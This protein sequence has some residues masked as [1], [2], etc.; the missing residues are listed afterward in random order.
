MSSMSFLKSHALPTLAVASMLATPLAFALDRKIERGSGEASSELT[1]TDATSLQ[2]ASPA[3]TNEESEGAQSH[4]PLAVNVSKQTIR[5]HRVLRSTSGVSCRTIT[6]L[7][8]R[9]KQRQCKT[10]A[11]WLAYVRERQDDVYLKAGALIKRDGSLG[12]R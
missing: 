8:S 12:E 1:A 3:K 7:N 11:E 6:R 10:N 9:I 4:K 5:S 2:E